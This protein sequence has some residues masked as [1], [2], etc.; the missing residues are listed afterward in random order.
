MKK[1]LSLIIAALV[2]AACSSSPSVQ[3]PSA[4]SQGQPTLTQ[5]DGSPAVAGEILVKYSGGVSLSSAP[6]IVG[7]QT[8][9]SFSSEGFGTL[10]RVSVPKGQEIAYAQQFSAQ[11]GVEYA[12]PNFWIPNRR[13]GIQLNRAGISALTNTPPPPAPSPLA[14]T[15]PY[16]TQVPGGDPFATAG[17]HNPS[18]LFVTSARGTLVVGGTSI[19]VTTR[20]AANGSSIQLQLPL[21]AANTLTGQGTLQPNGRD[22][23]GTFTIKPIVL[24][25]APCNATCSTGTWTATLTGI[26]QNTSLVDAS[27]TQVRTFTFAGS[28]TA[29]PAT[30]TSLNGTLTLNLTGIFTYSR[31]PWLW[32]IHRIDAPSAWA[33]GYTGQGVVVA[34]VDEG[35]DLRHPDLAP[36]LWVN[37][38]PSNPL[39]PGVNG[40]NFADENGDPTDTGGHGTH[41]AGTV[42]G[43]A[44]NQGVVGVAPRAKLMIVRGLSYFGGSTYMLV[45]SLKYVAD[46]GA[47]VSNNSWGGTQ[48]SRAFEDVLRYGTAKG[49]VYVFSA[50]NGFDS[51]NAVSD[52]V[53]NSVR[54]AGVI[55]VGA[56]SANNL[57]TAFSN[58]G[59]YV[60]V[61]APGNA[62][63]S[64]IPQEQNPADPYGFLQGTSMAAP[65]VTGV[66]ALMFSAKPDLTPLQVRVAL[67]Q[68]ANSVLTGQLARPDY[69]SAQPGQFGYGLV[70]AKAAVDYVRFVY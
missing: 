47:K 33:D 70:D 13:Q 29:G 28:A 27:G 63:L 66:V 3:G 61:A 6:E 39:C 17:A 35:A 53:G 38:N 24:G 16:F 43:A 56:T 65:H 37:P 25:A 64:T 57:R 2:L 36:N 40:Y 42:A 20:V 50:G 22:Y 55:G 31:V 15:D 41:T 67:E 8:L 5:I 11:A 14:A 46:C 9:E 69:Q 54:I 62:V 4:P 49:H 59:R 45:R 10:A 34:I 23:A 51:S 18:G 58:T 7:S 1:T 52:P 48:R 44:N 32:G 30:G 60:T 21:D 19:A 68:T 26:S 12:E